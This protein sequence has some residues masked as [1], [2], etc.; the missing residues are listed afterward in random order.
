MPPKLKRVIDPEKV[1]SCVLRGNKKI[2][3][4]IGVSNFIIQERFQ[5]SITRNQ[6]NPARDV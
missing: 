4:E 6:E 3:P 1:S 2:S 5:A